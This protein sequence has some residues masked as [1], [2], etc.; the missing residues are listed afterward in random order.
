MNEVPNEELRGEPTNRVQV[1]VPSIAP[2]ITYAILGFTVFVY[3]MQLLSVAILGYAV[4]DLDWLLVLG[5]RINSAVHDGQLWR[6][7]TPMFLHFSFQHIFFNMYGLF[8]IG[9]FLEKQLG[10][11][12]FLLLYLLG[13]FAGN[14]FSFL[15]TREGISAGASGAIFA[16]VAAEAVFFYQNRRL[17]GD[18]AKKALGNSAFIVI[19]NVF[20]GV[21][22]GFDNW[23]HL[24]G[25]LGGAMFAWFAGTR[26]KVVGIQPMLS[27]EDEREPKD[28][29]TGTAMVIIVFVMLAVWGMFFL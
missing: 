28:T 3:L 20:L 1:V 13:G 9:S 2:T 16:L 11:W 29:V 27:L 15:F 17:F 18:Y 5:G 22:L 14:V 12:R 10:H 8:S 19:I 21:S 25:F 23:G 6:L 7:I 24:G 26:W 4:Y